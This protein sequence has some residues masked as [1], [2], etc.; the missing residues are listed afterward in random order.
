[1]T[2]EREQKAAMT[3]QVVNAAVESA[4]GHTPDPAVSLYVIK[5]LP[6]AAVI[7]A[8]RS[9]ISPAPLLALLDGEF[10]ARA[11]LEGRDLPADAWNI[12]PDI[13]ISATL[14]GFD[15]T[16]RKLRFHFERMG[17]DSWADALED[18]ILHARRLVGPTARPATADEAQAFVNHVLRVLPL[19]ETWISLDGDAK[20]TPRG[21][22]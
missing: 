1:M 21:V 12:P 13:S 6:E 20:A 8:K 9:G 16:S 17:S 18:Y 22:H 3:R 11:A 5:T 10:A 14:R 19:F 2:G 7:S 15:E 4:F